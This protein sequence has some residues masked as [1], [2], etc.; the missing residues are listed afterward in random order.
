MR[1]SQP[2][3]Y[4][5]FAD[6]VVAKW[7]QKSPEKTALLSVDESGKEA[8]WSFREIHEQSSRLA[9][10]LRANG[11]Q[12]GAT[13]LV[14]LAGLPFRVIA[15]LAVMKVGGVSLLVRHESTAREVGH[16]LERARSRLALVGPEDAERFPSAAGM[17]VLPSR[18]LENQ[19]RAAPSE[20]ASHRS[21]SDEPAQIMLTGGTTGPPK[22]VLHTHASKLFHYLRWTVSFE[23][24]DLS[25]DFAGRWWMGAWRQ[26]TTVFDRVIPQR[27]APGL[28]LETLARYPITRLMAPARVY[29][30]LVRERSVLLPSLRSCWS[31]GQALDATVFRAWRQM[32]GITLHDRYNQSEC[33]EAPVEPA[34]QMSWEPGCIGKPF[35]WMKMAVIDPQGRR[36]PAGELGNLAIQVKPVRPPS[37]FREYWGDPDA[38]AARHTGD[39]YLTGDIGR[40]SQAGFIFQIGRAHV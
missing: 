12:R 29:A 17:L 5:N 19:L 21:R 26:G 9:H 38:T 35:P 36:L 2:P 23:P 24:D 3:E 22:M 11:L 32:T 30:R 20:F 7:A 15:Q 8:H 31:S 14:M 34:D 6:D 25:W 13:V 37:L 27:A 28:I 4:F 40:V 16:H 18:Q 39:W 10:V 1:A 33:G